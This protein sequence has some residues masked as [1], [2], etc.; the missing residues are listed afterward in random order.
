MG[1]SGRG[2]GGGLVGCRASRQK[3][4][5]FFMLRATADQMPG[6]NFLGGH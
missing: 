6:T 4:A 5:L 1:G 3:G 2:G